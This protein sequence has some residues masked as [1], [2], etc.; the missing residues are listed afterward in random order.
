MS[1]WFEVY[2]FDSIGDGLAIY[3]GWKWILAL[4]LPIQYPS[5]LFLSCSFPMLL[6][7]VVKTKWLIEGINRDNSMCPCCC[8]PCLL[9]VCVG[10]PA[11]YLLL[12]R[13]LLPANVHVAAQ[14]CYK[15]ITKTENFPDNFIWFESFQFNENIFLTNTFHNFVHLSFCISGQSIYGTNRCW[16]L[17]HFNGMWLLISSVLY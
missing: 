15:V 1:E 6:K 10:V 14:N 2:W 17:Q 9:Q 4:K 13:D 12:A 16:D 11:P 8:I 7:V 5:I 3:L